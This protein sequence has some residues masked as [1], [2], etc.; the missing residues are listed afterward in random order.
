MRTYIIAF[1]AS[2]MLGLPV[3]A[4][5]GIENAL[6]NTKNST[7]SIKVNEII[8]GWNSS[9]GNRQQ[10][11]KLTI[12]GKGNRFEPV[13][14]FAHKIKGIIVNKPDPSTTEPLLINQ[15][16]TINNIKF[17]NFKE[18]L[19]NY[20][21]K[22]SLTKT[23]F[24]DNI[25]TGNGAAVFN[26]SGILTISSSVFT[27]NKSDINGGAIYIQDDG[28]DIKRKTNISKSK[29]YGNT[30]KEAGG[31]V[32]VDS[33]N[34]T[35]KSDTFGDALNTSNSAK[36][37]GALYNNGD[38]TQIISS[39]FSNNNAEQGGD[40]YNAGSLT[41]SKSTFGVKPKN[42]DKYGSSAKEGGAIYNNGKLIISSSSFNQGNAEN[43]GALYN[44]GTII[45]TD[46]NGKEIAGISS[47]KF[48]YNTAKNGG[49]VY[50]TGRFF[51]NKLTFS[52]NIA[53]IY[54]GAVYNYSE[55][56]F[57]LTGSTFSNN[58]AE[59]GGAIY[60]NSV[61]DILSSTFILN[62]ADD[63]GAIYNDTD[64][65]LTLTKVTFG[66]TKKKQKY[67]NNS[68]RGSALFNKGTANLIS[69]N[70][71][72]N[73]ADEGVI[74]NINN[75]TL[76]KSKISYNT[77]NFGALY[78]AAGA[79]SNINNGSSFSN[80]TAIM[81]GAVY[82][83]GTTIANVS[84]FSSNIATGSSEEGNTYDANGGAVYNNG[85]FDANRTT[86]SSN[87]A[88][89]GGAIYNTNTANLNG[90]TFSKNSGVYGGAVYNEEGAVTILNGVKYTAIVKKKEVEKVSDLTFSKNT[91]VYG[92]AIYNVGTV[93]FAE[94]SDLSVVS[95]KFT[96]NTATF[97]SSSF[98]I[99]KDDV[100][101]ESKYIT[102]KGGAIYNYGT[103]LEDKQIR[104]NDKVCALG[105]SV[106]VTTIGNGQIIYKDNQVY[107]YN[108]QKGTQYT[109]GTNM[110][111]KIVFNG[112]VY[113]LND[114]NITSTDYTST[115]VLT[116]NQILYNG[117]LYDISKVENASEYKECTN[118]S[119][120]GYQFVRDGKIYSIKTSSG[121][122]Y[123]PDKPLTENQ[124]VYNNRVCNFS[125]ED[126]VGDYEVN[127]TILEE[128]QIVVGSRIYKLVNGKEYTQDTNL[129][130]S[131]IVINGMVYT[132]EFVSSY[133]APTVLEIGQI[134]SSNKVYTLNDETL[135]KDNDKILVYLDKDSV[136]KENQVIYKGRV[137]NL[138]DLTEIT[139]YVAGMLNLDKAVFTSNSA[140]NKVVLNVE[141]YVDEKTNDKISQKITFY[142]GKGG[143]I[144]N[145]S[146]ADL[147]I[148]DSTFSKNSASQ[149]GGA[150]ANDQV[151]NNMYIKNS[152]FTSN[153]S[154]STVTTV[155]TT[156]NAKG[157]KSS[158]TTKVNVGNGGAIYTLGNLYINSEEDDSLLT[159]FKSNSAVNG[160]AIYLQG[161]SKIYN[162]NFVSNSAVYG[163]AVYINK[164]ELIDDTEKI[165][166]IANSLFEKN[167]AN[168]GGA[169][170]NTG[171]A[172][173]I[174]NEF[175][176]NNG[177]E[178]AGAIYNSG[179]MTQKEGLFTNNNCV[180]G[181][182]IL[183]AGTYTDGIIET[184]SETEETTVS[185]GSTFE[186]NKAKNGAGG[187]IYNV[188]TMTL[189]G[190]Y[191]NNNN[192][193][194]GG[195]VYNTG[196][197]T[198]NNVVFDNTKSVVNY[199]GGAIYNYNSLE[200]NN[201]EFN[202]NLAAA[203]GGAIM[204][205]KG[206][207]GWYIISGSVTSSHN[208]YT[209]NQAYSGG[210]I[211]SDAGVLTSKD[212]KFTK[213]ISNFGGAIFNNATAKI[214][215]SIFDKNESFY[216]GAVCSGNKLEIKGGEFTE[217]DGYWGG[218][219]YNSSTLKKDD[220]VLLC[221]LTIDGTT[222]KGNYGRINAGA[223]YIAEANT[224]INN[225]VFEGNHAEVLG[226]AILIATND[227]K[228]VI[229]S[230]KFIGNYVNANGG[231]VYNAG[232][233]DFN[234]VPEPEEPDESEG[235][236][237]QSTDISDGSEATGGGDEAEETPEPIEYEKILFEGNKA[238]NGGA[239]YNIG[240]IKADNISFKG[241]STT[242]HGGAIHNS[243][244]VELSNAIFEGNKAESTKIE[245]KGGAVYNNA[246]IEKKD[247]EPFGFVAY[248]SSFNSN[249]ADLGGAIYN[250]SNL[251]IGQNNRNDGTYDLFDTELQDCFFSENEAKNGG[252]LYNTGNSDVLGT[253]ITNNKASSNGGAIYNAGYLLSNNVKYDGNRAGEDSG[254]GAI[255]SSSKY[256]LKLYNSH[257]TNNKAKNGG[258]VYID[259]S[260][261]YNEKEVIINQCEFG[262][263][264]KETN[265]VSEGNIVTGNGGAIYIAP[266]SKVKIL[267]SAFYGNSAQNG[268]AIYAGTNST[269]TI[270]DT[271]FI[272]NTAS[273]NGGAIY[274]DKNSNVRV[275]AENNN[276]V[277]DGNL[278]NG[279]S[280][281]IYL[282]QATLNL[283]TYENKKITINDH[284]AGSGTIIVN[285]DI[286]IA[287]QA[288][289]ES[290]SDITFKN[291]GKLSI[292]NED[293]L[294]GMSLE[295]SENSLLS[296]ANNKI[297]T[298]SINKL[299]LADNT[300]TNISID[301]DLKNSASDKI[302]A[303]TVEGT[304]SLNV[305]KVN[306]ISNSK[307]PVTVDLSEN[308]VVSTIS[309]TTAESAE[310]T[311][312]LK[313]YLD[314]NG[315]LMAVAYG[316]KAKPCALAA[317]V[318]AQIG[319]YLTQINSYDQA[320]MN[321]DMNM[322][323]TR[324]ERQSERLNNRYA[325]SDSSYT[326]YSE[327]NGINLNSKGLW[328]RP[329]ATFERVNLN[330]GPK[331]SNIGYGNFF[332]G[333]AEV[334]EL[335]N[336]W[337]R[338][339]SAYVGY[340]GSIQD[341]D[342][343]SI[344]QNGGTLGVTEVWY[345]NNF[346]TGLTANVGA[347]SVNANTDLGNENFPMLM[348]GVASKSGYN[349]EFKDGKFVIQPSLLLSYSFVH[350]FSH[351]NGRG[352]K[353]GSSPLHAIQ[354]APGVKFIFNL[355]K[356]WQPYL[357]VNMR[358][359][360]IDK[361]HFSLQ[362][363]SIP[364][365]SIDPYVEYGIGIQRRWGERFTG[366][367]QAMIRNGGRN[368]V[369]LSFGF[370]WAIGK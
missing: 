264:D 330:N 281:A 71:Y 244:Y 336:G 39:K 133:T 225:A 94:D 2:M 246:P 340:N 314:S 236:K 105:D 81:G 72:Y 254:G 19:T 292:A 64:G 357:G 88:N 115:S 237:E 218:A 33:G 258:A 162:S 310:A 206:R 166:L 11:Q 98:D 6:Q 342:R 358:W 366:Y 245:N 288:E 28:L 320:F 287:N 43:G 20:G 123:N 122:I 266:K 161:A 271:D 198:L 178:A 63:G 210:A 355:P 70:I 168:N 256:S 52:G 99:T 194:Y 55:Q 4:V 300:K 191:F 131:T 338:Q 26:D 350:T 31:A 40:I 35:F 164:P 165:A 179:T 151:D 272:G 29:F 53:E 167:K 89:N 229:N 150:I 87:K 62:T 329:Y 80:N 149:A 349:F 112:F 92:G 301:M 326:Q 331:V 226:G 83:N 169:I 220:K 128:N 215:N 276:V 354:V 333:D 367:G 196:K 184:D 7:Y 3:Y 86:F 252:A 352:N 213:N 148:S 8:E 317:P 324:E 104:Y 307:T 275:V 286:S 343:Q 101:D 66:N 306:L 145:S 227:D 369:M 116:D 91:A 60:N 176:S 171:T 284:I 78:T 30:A 365:M 73:I 13:L 280:N 47:V 360:I 316:Q 51:G 132:K 37:G 211:Y 23:D 142:A 65:V 121:T 113:D 265:T 299:V 189:N 108:S 362:D 46:K 232:T 270:T 109:S 185:A 34:V 190:T 285:G 106:A 172:E 311:Y 262:Q 158:K 327:D 201:S 186:E 319:G 293:N 134:I 259:S 45:S 251:V 54:G 120:S 147:N 305:D 76:D 124:I 49:A 175:S 250:V 339:F 345:K 356:G 107:D 5:S 182:A 231:A 119:N 181:G 346:F 192:A 183:N 277:F 282:K 197:A 111:D 18:A 200:I 48:N 152:T 216:G 24:K 144:Y 129:S 187:A 274:A 42:V 199:S 309:T 325:S 243:Y 347:N 130:S 79:V 303:E 353:V 127:A 249:K 163:G 295:M 32:Y 137:Y 173:L 58:S 126:I 359:N 154:K 304:G 248:K 208:S 209:D 294:K 370:K 59:L 146:S 68:K 153:T 135:L 75:L 223:I 97:K 36:Q 44:N 335:N 322:L 170:Y 114:K 228:A 268:G 9:N 84:T 159:T 323:K 1:L 368:G 57:Y 10:A 17:V 261:I 279:K 139:D 96:S 136:D 90:S 141:Q 312:K 157:K 263:I 22:V 202:N 242:C 291:N 180:I 15:Q 247:D 50:N 351:D 38:N 297:R 155:T 21:G 193:V 14:E 321:M 219:V 85:T 56:L 174:N 160:G 296:T 332:G 337:K 241:N 253:S 257:F 77:T 110:K 140:K 100:G 283:L 230:T 203:Y 361:T 298:L 41:I 207:Q 224:T 118:F 318:A 67:A 273:E 103:L 222:F 341:Y 12:K 93:N 334:K 290:D 260:K 25:S 117:K 278:A 16:L 235:N 363:V 239:I 188:G 177:T 238:D 328:T 204:N 125:D 143:A 221:D 344:D 212:D 240:N 61:M 217:N 138:S 313:Q 95:G 364:D 233:L 27:S 102:A 214:E 195:S 255:Y 156:I 205:T 267:N 234:I 82:N 315:R 302:V 289:L 74:Y 269:L 348:A 308:S 69:S